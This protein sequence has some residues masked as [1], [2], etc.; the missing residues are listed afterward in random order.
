MQLQVP[1]VFLR[2]MTALF[3]KH[4]VQRQRASFQLAKTGCAAVR[5]AG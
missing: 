4:H 3:L 5:D 1:D 2:A